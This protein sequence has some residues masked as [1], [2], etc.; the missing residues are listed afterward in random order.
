MKIWTHTALDCLP[1]P[2]S[3]LCS[4]SRKFPLCYARNKTERYTAGQVIT[5]PYLITAFSFH[6]I[7][8]HTQG[9]YKSGRIHKTTGSGSMYTPWHH[10]SMLVPHTTQTNITTNHAKDSRM[11]LKVEQWEAFGDRKHHENKNTRVESYEKSI[12]F[13]TVWLM[14]PLPPGISHVMQHAII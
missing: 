9:W 11:S 2:S 7:M 5:H 3:C 1:H 6:I 4:Y 14:T 8:N 10:H 13:S 12:H